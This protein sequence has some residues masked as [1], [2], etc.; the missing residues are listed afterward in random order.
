MPPLVGRAAQLEKLDQALSLVSGGGFAV[1]VVSGEPGIGKT[2]LLD[3]LSWRA[4]AAGLPVCRAQATELAQQVPFALFAEALH[5]LLTAQSRDGT[6]EV[7][8]ALYGLGGR[9]YRTAVPSADRLHLHSVVRRMLERTGRSGVAILLDDLHWADRA[10]LELTEYLIRKPPLVPLLLTV[11]FRSGRPPAAVIDV[12]ARHGPA[13]TWIVPGPLNSADLGILFPHAGER[14]RDQ[15]LRASRGNPLYAQ[16]LARFAEPTLTALTRPGRIELGEATAAE[17]DILAGLAG[18][19]SFLAEPAQQVAYAVAAIGDQAP[20]DLVAGVAGLPLPAAL[21][22]VAQLCGS[23]LLV[24]DRNQLSFWHPLLRAAAYEL[25]G[26]AWRLAARARAAD[27][28]R[29]PGRSRAAARPADRSAS[30]RRE[31]S[32]LALVSPR[33]APE[34]GDQPALTTREREIVQLVASG[35][36]NQEIAARLHLSRRTVE[37]HLARIYTKLQVRSRTGMLSRLSRP[38]DLSA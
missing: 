18:E 8:A 37:S 23:G 21:D 1:V 6:D 29:R 17:R 13:V 36:T 9:A 28:L 33:P 30:T 34:S 35:L 4:N 14:R 24:L 7:G 31:S 20:V 12:I 22:V 38:A 2:R 32:P 19:I 11:T 15:I 16:V 5:P 25:A 10:S 26:A 27:H 3:E